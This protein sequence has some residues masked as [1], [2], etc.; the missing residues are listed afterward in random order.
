MVQSNQKVEA[1]V[2][3]PEYYL[4]NAQVGIPTKDGKIRINKDKEALKSYFLTYVNP[5]TQFFTTLEE[6]I[7]YLLREDYL[8]KEV[9]AKYSMKQIK[10][11]YQQAHKYKHRFM[12][13]TSAHKFYEQYA[14]KNRKGT[15][16]L[17][18]YEDIMVWV[19]MSFANGD[20]ELAKEYVDLMMSRAFTPATPTLLNIG[21]NT[22]GM[23]TSCYLLAFQD[24]LSSIRRVK[25]DGE[26]LSALGGGVSFNLINVRE[27]GAPIRG[28]EGLASGVVPIA[29]ILEDIGTYA[30]Q[31]GKEVCHRTVEIDGEWLIA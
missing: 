2:K 26:A 24:N 3:I 28:R 19:S 25:A 1:K 16:F 15:R 31:G 22:G 10:S 14:L 8:D 18:R 9:F 21:R 12:S 13:F 11:L 4:I 6:K 5:N 20:Y 17:G 23:Y 29:K 30:N 27:T 7:N